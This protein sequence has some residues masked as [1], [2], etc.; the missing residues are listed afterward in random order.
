[1]IQQSNAGKANMRKSKWGKSE[2]ARRVQRITHLCKPITAD[3][4]ITFTQHL[5]AVSVGTGSEC[6][7][8]GCTDGTTFSVPTN[9]YGNVKFNGENVGPHQ[10]AYC[11][12]AGITLAELDGY[13]VHHAAEFGR[14]LGYRCCNPDHLDMVPARKHYGTQGTKDSLV[15]V[16]TKIIREVLGVPTRERHP[17]ELLNVA[18]AGF[19]QR[20]LGGIPFRIRTAALVDVLE[21][22]SEGDSEQ[23]PALAAA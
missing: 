18:G 3:R 2:K 10:F 1:M 19:K 21:D 23:A 6:W 20:C 22:V 12:A 13:H 11:V 4:I 5:V 14:C 16:H 15:P 17:V 7:F 9:H 8:Y